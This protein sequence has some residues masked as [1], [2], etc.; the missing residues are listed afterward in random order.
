[1]EEI[2]TYEAVAIK[3]RNSGPYLTRPPKT[4]E[5]Q[6]ILGDEMRQWVVG[7]ET[8][9]LEAFPISK[10]MSPSRFFKIAESNEYFAECL[11]FARNVIG[12]RLQ[13]GWRLR[14][15]DKDYVLR[16]LLL[17]NTEYKKLTLDKMRVVED[18]K[19]QGNNFSIT[20]HPIPSET[21]Q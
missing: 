10:S 19:N 21:K 11:D 8:F 3:V 4:E 7:E 17:Y 15:L 14:T 2:K 12:I 18:S 9:C 6:N 16:I 1:M 5:A 20:M 13:D